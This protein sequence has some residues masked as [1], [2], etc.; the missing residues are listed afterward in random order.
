MVKLI[1][2][3]PCHNEEE[4]LGVTLDALPREIPG[5][6]TVQWLVIDDGSTDRTADVAREHGV[7]HIVNMRTNRGLARAFTVG[8]DRS[9]RLGT[10]IIVNTHAGNQYCADDIPKLVDPILRGQA[11]IVIGQR[12]I[13]DVGHFSGVTKLL[14]RLASWVVRAASGT[15]IPD[16]LS[17]F[18]ALSREAAIRLNVF[19]NYTYTLETIIQAGR[20]NMAITSVP[21]QTNKDLQPPSLLRSIP[22]HVRPS[23]FT[24][25]RIFMTYRPF[26]FFAFPGTALLLVGLYP[27]IRYLY[28]YL[29]AVPG[30]QVGHV[31]SL[32]FGIFFIGTGAAL[33]V[34]G[35]LA[36]LIGVNRQ[37][38]EDFRWRQREAEYREHLK[39]FGR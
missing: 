5:I 37:L 33:I 35:L 29:S 27:G 18:R 39:R 7:D 25:V 8:L 32:L 10:D 31:Q 36:E 20:R 17:G 4:S 11:E 24:I 30:E 19:D 14:Q 6:D 9:I 13:S 1:I 34:V 21:V 16:A 23:I 26:R 28:Y 38:L 12:P 22:S 15:K 3:I 2:Q